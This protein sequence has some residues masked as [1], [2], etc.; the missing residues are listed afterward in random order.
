MGGLGMTRD[1]VI[2]WMEENRDERGMKHWDRLGESGEG[3]MTSYGVG[4]TRLRKFAKQVGK[5]HELAG[6][7]W[8]VANHEVKIVALLIDEPKKI[9]RE[10][11][12]AQVEEV[13]PGSLGHVFSSC[14]A[15]LA[16]A[17]FAGELAAA[18]MESEDPVRRRCAY[19][20]VY[21]LSKSTKKSAP[22]DDFYAGCIKRIKKDIQGE[23]N[24]V[25]GSML[26]AFLGI[27]KRSK[28]LNAEAIRAVKAI[29]PVD[30]DYGDSG[31]EPLDVMKHL[32][33]DRLRKKLTF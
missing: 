31:C 16:K 2:A 21:E 20:L 30:V 27:G 19:G 3:K 24:W 10:Q 15:P 23:E 26:G 29:G 5:S 14:D 1:E 28:E 7:L 4:L 6:E 8:E 25:K 18:W 9:T 33:S 13:G 12:E 22:G 32:T 17:A 11:V